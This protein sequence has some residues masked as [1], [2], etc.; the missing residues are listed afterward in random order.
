MSTRAAASH[1][2]INVKKKDSVAT[3]DFIQR[4][5]G[6]IRPIGRPPTLTEGHREFMVEWADSNTDSV[7]QLC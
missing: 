7:T 3:Q 1:L 5:S 4:A 6:S 2:N